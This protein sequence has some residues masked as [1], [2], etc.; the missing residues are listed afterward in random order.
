MQHV[1]LIDRV[2]IRAARREPVDLSAFEGTWLNTNW[3]TQGIEK[4]V[5]SASDGGLEV[6]V[7]AA[8]PDGLLDW[9]PVTGATIYCS[10]ITSN[11]GSAFSVTYDFGFLKT[12]LEGNINRGVLVLAAYNAFEEG[13]GRLSYF[14]REYFSRVR[15]VS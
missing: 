8:G 2:E 9:G 1:R 10:G 14:S 13:D 12:R 4:V 11:V 5:M 6:H 3:Q 7:F 15:R